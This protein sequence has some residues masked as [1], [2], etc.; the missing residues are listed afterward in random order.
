MKLRLGRFNHYL[1]G[2]A[3]AVA[4]AG[5][6]TSKSSTEKKDATSLRLF[7]ESDYD[8]GGKTDTVPIYRSS[9]ILV[10]VEKVPF[11][12]EGSLTEAHVVD[13][14]GGFA[15]Q[16]KFNFH[17]TLI[18]EQITTSYKGRRIAVQAMYTE[19][20]WLGAP[21]IAQRIPDG[22]FTFTPDATREEAQ[23]I[24][25]G[26]NNVA[27]KLGNAPKSKKKSDDL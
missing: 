3:L 23:R 16:L 17:G 22:Y 19:G 4:L 27:A 20:R 6:A 13:T 8:T 21:M 1:L 26:L 24:V 5:C 2:A 25:R 15:I 7:L 11:L 14:V 9:P 10:K 12:D 18:L